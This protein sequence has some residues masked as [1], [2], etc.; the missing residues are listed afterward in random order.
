MRILVH[1]CCG[2]CSIVVFRRLVQA[3]HE[4]CGLFFNPNIQPL[5]EYIKRREGAV[6]TA[7]NLSVPILLPDACVS[8]DAPD[9]KQGDWIKPALPAAVDPVPWL[10]AVSGRENERCVFCWR[11]R[12]EKCA[13]IAQKQGYEAFCTSLLYSRHQ[14]HEK[15][16]ALGFAAASARGL[17]FVYEDFRIYWKEGVELSRDWG[18]YRQQYC[19]CIFSEYERYNRAFSSLC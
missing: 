14:D 17:A 11:L 19:G 5:S 1:M 6:E 12:I 7:R 9:E 15:I 18:I 13:E 4:C 8:F 2:P 16:R 3:G 10:R